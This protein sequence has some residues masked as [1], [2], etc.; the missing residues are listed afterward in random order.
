MSVNCPVCQSADNLK[1]EEY[2]DY[3]L[4]HCNGCDVVFS[5]PMKSEASFY[6]NSM[7]YQ[8][9]DRLIM[10]PIK[11]DFRWD[12]LE[13]LK[14]PPRE[15]GSLLDIGCGTGYFVKRA[16]SLGY[17]AHGIET[18]S[19]SV[20]SGRRFFGLETIHATDLGG[21]I[22]KLPGSR[23]NVVSLFQVLEHLEDPGHL[24]EEAKQVMAEE[25]VLVIAV[26]LRERWPDTSGTDGDYPPHHLTR[27][28]LKSLEYILDKHGYR[29][30][31]HVTEG[32]PLENM[33]TLIYNYILKLAPFLTLKGKL[34]NSGNAHSHSKSE[35]PELTDEE[36][37]GVLKKRKLKM[38]I[39]TVTGIPIWLVLKALGAKGPN[40]Y[41]EAVLK[42]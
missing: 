3:V 6:E 15:R 11:W 2:R 8:L 13:F 22:D 26:P 14:N 25:S 17:S 9:R 23:F 5:D 32:F 30:R 37:L 41:L 18:N 40:I 34:K 4:Y 35:M 31:K 12:M 39:A 21:F 10:D 29:I 27:W 24:L 42:P 36:A 28:S 38:N 33:P 19:R 7:D 1:V 16:Q 20:E